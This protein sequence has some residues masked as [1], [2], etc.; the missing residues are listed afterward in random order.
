[1]PEQKTS[2]NNTDLTNN[3]SEKK[4]T[5]SRVA[6]SKKL[7][8]SKKAIHPPK[9][10]PAKKV[11]LVHFWL[12]GMRGGEKVL[13]S[14]CRMYPQADIFTHVLDKAALSPLLQSHNIYTTF[15]QK[16]PY[17]KKLYQKYLPLMPLALEQL[18]L[19]D[20]DLVISSES[21]PAKGV[22]THS[23]STHVCYC[24]TPMRYLWDLYHEYLTNA[25]WPVRMGMRVCFPRLRTWDV[26]SAMRVDHFVANSKTV[27]KRINKTWKREASVVHPPVI[28]DDYMLSTAPREDFYL[29]VGQLVNYKR[30]DLA[31]QACTRLGRRLLVVGEGEESK[32]WQAMAGPTVDFL[33]R[34]PTSDIINLYGKCKALLFPGEEDFG[35]VPV[36]AMATGAPVIAFGKGGATE[37]VVSEETGIFFHEQSVDALCEAISYFESKQ[38]QF[39]AKNIRQLVLHFEEANFR[40]KMFAEIERARLNNLK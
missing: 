25:S 39:D 8:S 19:S 18:N 36:E 23:N 12:V 3:S 31:I 4:S 1:M 11:A 22:L 24:H 32:K 29:C 27:A 9:L 2:T 21:G 10:E 34:I 20:Y 7:T 40:E 35:L 26:L 15:I 6:T 5:R 38:S 13:E 30:V 16:L 14:L 28:M 33:G 17:S 37:T